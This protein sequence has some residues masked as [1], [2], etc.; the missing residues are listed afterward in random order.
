M[1]IAIFALLSTGADTYLFIYRS[2]ACAAR[3][4]IIVIRTLDVRDLIIMLHH[5]LAQQ[6][7]IKIILKWFCNARMC[8]WLL[9]EAFFVRRFC[10]HKCKPHMMWCGMDLEDSSCM[11]Y[12]VRTR[13]LCN[14]HDE[15]VAYVHACMYTA[16]VFSRPSKASLRIRIHTLEL[17]SQA[18]YSTN[19][20]CACTYTWTIYAIC[21][22]SIV[23]SICSKR[24]YFSLW[25]TV[26]RHNVNTSSCSSTLQHITVIA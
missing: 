16:V 9:V 1:F 13:K 23:Y 26:Q 17:Q 12:V 21:V 18:Q 3:V 8:I 6:R 7:G 11:E 24:V 22:C 14:S 20:H 4:I 5:L 2:C 25:W 10:H 19:V 15:H